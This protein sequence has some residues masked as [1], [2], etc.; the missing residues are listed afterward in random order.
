MAYSLEHKTGMMGVEPGV[1]QMNTQLLT[2]HL[3]E[4]LAKKQAG[5]STENS[6]GVLINYLKKSKRTERAKGPFYWRDKIHHNKTELES[7]WLHVKAIA[8]EILE[9]ERKLGAGESHHTVCHPSPSGDCRWKC[10]FYSICSLHD[11]GSDV[12]AAIEDLYETHDPLERY[13]LPDR[14]DQ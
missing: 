6:W 4:Y 13:A 9:A 8:D 1:L 12:E 7:H 10:S 11:D 14:M 5:E 2:Q 3:V